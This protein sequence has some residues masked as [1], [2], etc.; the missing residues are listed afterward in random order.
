MHSTVTVRLLN[1]RKTLAAGL[2]YSSH[3][4]SDMLLAFSLLNLPC[5]HSPH[6]VHH[7][8][9]SSSQ[10]SA[11]PT[12][13]SPPPSY[14][15]INIQPVMPSEV[16]IDTDTRQETTAATSARNSLH[17]YPHS[18]RLLPVLHD[19]AT[20]T[21]LPTPFAI[22]QTLFLPPLLHSYYARQNAKIKADAH[23]DIYTTVF[24]NLTAALPIIMLALRVPVRFVWATLAW[25]AWIV[26]EI[27]AVAAMPPSERDDCC[28][29]KGGLGDACSLFLQSVV[30]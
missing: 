19:I 8:M 29:C 14:H 9:K 27:A 7:K 3:Q 23:E 12:H 4:Q 25:T 11:S 15:A 24:V 21:W 17:D 20:S 13:N 18:Q 10:P 22:L 5:H 16:I 26:W 6:Y 1:W 2:T 28:G 30:A